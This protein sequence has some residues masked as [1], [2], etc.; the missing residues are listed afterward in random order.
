M[1]CMIGVSLSGWG[2]RP[3]STMMPST[4]STVYVRAP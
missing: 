1:G 2:V 4:G 3:A